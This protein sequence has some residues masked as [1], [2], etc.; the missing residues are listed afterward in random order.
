MDSLN[1]PI[2]WLS[3][4][5]IVYVSFANKEEKG[6][7]GPTKIVLKHLNGYVDDGF[8]Q[9]F[10]YFPGCRKMV[11]SPLFPFPLHDTHHFPIVESVDHQ[12]QREPQG[13]CQPRPPSCHLQLVRVISSYKISLL[14]L[15]QMLTEHLLSTLCMLVQVRITQRSQATSRDAIVRNVKVNAVGIRMTPRPE[16]LGK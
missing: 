11:L 1:S 16:N 9:T 5:M 13:L 6:I 7:S 12:D 15:N 2:I 10:L 14:P 3:V 8:S 4:E